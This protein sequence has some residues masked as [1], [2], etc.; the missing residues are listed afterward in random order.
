MSY[1]CFSLR[2]E[3]NNGLTKLIITGKSAPQLET[4]YEFSSSYFSWFL[5]LVPL[6]H[7]HFPLACVFPLALRDIMSCPLCPYQVS[8]TW[9]IS[10][11]GYQMAGCSCHA[12]EYPLYWGENWSPYT[13]IWVFRNI[14][15]KYSVCVSFLACL[16]ATLISLGNTRLH[17]Q[18]CCHCGWWCDWNS[19][20]CVVLH[21][22]QAHSVVSD[23]LRPRGL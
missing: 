8:E 13:L 4:V 15:G 10:P 16:E 20:L 2:T 12:V 17:S 23:P 11:T 6:A 3:C 21:Y 5:P 9:I 22:V 14:S 19:Y 7:W 18:P 1:L